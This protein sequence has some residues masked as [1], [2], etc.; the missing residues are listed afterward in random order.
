MK[1][2][3]GNKARGR[4]GL[5]ETAELIPRRLDFL[6]SHLLPLILAAQANS[7]QFVFQAPVW[8]Q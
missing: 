5:A 7:L 6:V 8:P 4:L 3:A 2:N 1:D